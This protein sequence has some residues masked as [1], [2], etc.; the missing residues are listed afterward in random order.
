MPKLEKTQPTCSIVPK[1]LKASETLEYERPVE[2]KVSHVNNE[3]RM[4]EKNLAYYQALAESANKLIEHLDMIT[5]KKLVDILHS[6]MTMEVYT[7]EDDIA[8]Y[9]RGIK[10]IEHYIQTLEHEIQSKTMLME[11]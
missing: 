2:I 11:A 5:R 6:V 4:L 8:H 1:H 10:D 9:K 7:V 3:L